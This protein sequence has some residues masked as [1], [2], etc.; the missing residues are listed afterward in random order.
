M[1][2]YTDLAGRRFGR[3]VV[4]EPFGRDKNNRA[5]IWKCRCDCG[6]VHH[7]RSSSLNA[8]EV[9]SCGCLQRDIASQVNLTHGLSDREGYNNRIYRIWRNMKQRCSNPN[10]A[11]F[12]LYGGRGIKVCD[13]W[14]DYEPFHDW[15]MASG[16]RD[17]L[18]LERVDRDGRYEP[19]NCIWA[20]YKT[21]A[22][23]TGQNNLVTYKGETLPLVQWAEKAGIRYSTLRSRI[24]I[25][26]WSVEKAIETPVRERRAK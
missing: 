16:Y 25:Y 2:R 8:G 23:N 14:L 9:Q 18:T 7:A 13:E 21:Q 12:E 20:S 5:I 10:A 22:R 24:F 3:L 1:K 4:V 17:D 15:A 26:G 6:N 11:K 19:G